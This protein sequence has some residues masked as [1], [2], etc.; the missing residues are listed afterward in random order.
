MRKDLDLAR[1]VQDTGA[2]LVDLNLIAADAALDEA[3]RFVWSQ[4]FSG[5]GAEAVK[6]H[7]KPSDVAL[8]IIAILSPLSIAE[9][10]QVAFN[11][12][13]HLWVSSFARIPSSAFARQYLNYAATVHEEAPTTSDHR[14]R[15][16]KKRRADL[17]IVRG[18]RVH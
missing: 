7:L 1:I 16:D 14:E 13:C 12:R 6:G 17:S 2:C 9:V 15:Q 5:D 18:G 11:L 3:R 10:E 4:R 8:K